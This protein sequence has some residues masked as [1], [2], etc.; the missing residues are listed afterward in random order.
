MGQRQMFVDTAVSFLGRNEAD[1]S[2]REIIDIYNSHKPYAMGWAMTYTAPWCDAFV[3]AIAIKCGMTNIIPT[4]CGCERH[5]ELFKKRGDW[6]ESDDYTPKPGDIVFYDWQDNGVGDN[7]GESD[8]VGIVVSVGT[9]NLK[10]IEGNISN[11]VGYRTIDKNGKFIRGFAVPKFDEAKPEVKPAT[12]T[13]TEV[14]PASKTETKTETKGNNMIEVPVL[15]KGS[16]GES[17]RALQHLLIGNGISCGWRGADGDF[18]AMTEAAVRTYQG[19]KGLAKD[20]IV[21]KAT[22]TKL[23]GG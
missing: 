5:I 15:R 7:K 16:K 23:I 17:V 8:H 20:G 21:G 9:K 22:W 6:V 18:G 13:E 10:I 2:H 14:K 4:E 11:K 12:K 3:S 19:K 1:G